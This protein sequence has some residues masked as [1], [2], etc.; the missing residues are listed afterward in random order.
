MYFLVTAIGFFSIFSLDH[1]K[2]VEWIPG[3]VFRNFSIFV[4][5]EVYKPELV[6]DII[7][8]SSA[9]SKKLRKGTLF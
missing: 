9:A 5:Q 6:Q 8:K 1:G 7:K 2:Y 4:F 3:I